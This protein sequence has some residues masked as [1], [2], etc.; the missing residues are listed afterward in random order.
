MS[1]LEYKK[2]GKEEQFVGTRC[3]KIYVVTALGFDHIKIGYTF[4]DIK[5]GIWSPY[6]RSYGNNL[7]ILRIYPAC[8]KLEDI[9][10]HNHLTRIFSSKHKNT[11]KKKDE[12]YPKE[13][14]NFIL[15]ELEKW[16]L[17]PGVGPYY[18]DIITPMNLISVYNNE[19]KNQD[20]KYMM[21]LFKSKLIMVGKKETPN[22]YGLIKYFNFFIENKYFSENLIQ[23]FSGIY[24]ISYVIYYIFNIP[25]IKL[26]KGLYLLWHLYLGINYIRENYIQEKNKKDNIEDNWVYIN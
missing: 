14:T 8:Q 12:L 19:L 13:Y 9:K 5:K 15:K 23:N 3:H 22:T 11:K 16:C 7:I 17:H 1:F 21:D 18:K 26:T 24:S 2:F 6:H 25:S 10:I 4:L 20:G